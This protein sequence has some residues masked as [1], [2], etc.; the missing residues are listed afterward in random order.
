[1]YKKQFRDFK[2]GS[3]KSNFI[4]HL[5]DNHSVGTVADK[6]CCFRT[7]DPMTLAV[8]MFVF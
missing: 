4:G 7:K 5:L 2:T 6:A 3:S 1:M 8:Q